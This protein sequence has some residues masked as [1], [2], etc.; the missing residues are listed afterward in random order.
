MLIEW[1][2]LV[3]MPWSLMCAYADFWSILRQSQRFNEHL[4]ANIRGRQGRGFIGGC[5][6]HWWLPTLNPPS[7]SLEHEQPHQCV[8]EAA[9]QVKVNCCLS[10]VLGAKPPWF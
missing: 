4:V 2:G 10:Q 1:V 6:P 5:P 9:E 3:I 7:E 8:K